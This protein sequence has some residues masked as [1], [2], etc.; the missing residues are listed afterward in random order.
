MR[1]IQTFLSTIGC[2]LYALNQSK[3]GI[4]K[5]AVAIKARVV[6]LTLGGLDQFGHSLQISPHDLANRFIRLQVSKCNQINCNFCL[7]N[8]LIQ[9]YMYMHSQGVFEYHS[10]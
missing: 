5:V 3:E 6:I 4:L 1:Y 10:P 7:F 2:H 8:S 9:S